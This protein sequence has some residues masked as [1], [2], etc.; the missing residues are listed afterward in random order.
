LL[1]LT[2]A[3]KP[4]IDVLN[5]LAFAYTLVSVQESEKFT[6]RAMEASQAIDYSS[7]VAESFKI[8]GIVYYIRGEYNLATQY[9]YEA[10]KLYEVLLDKPGQARVLNNLALI[11]LA[12]EDFEKVYDLSMK[13][14]AIKRAAGDS[15][16]VATSY[17]ALAEVYL[18]QQRYADAMNQ[19]KEALNRYRQFG[20]EW[21]TSHA[22]L[23]VGEI[24]HAQKNYPFALSYYKDALRFAR[25]STDYIQVI[26]AYKKI[27]QLYL[28]TN[29]FDSAYYYVKSA[30]SLAR[31]KNNRNNEMQADQLL[32][33]YFSS[34][35]VLDSALFYT[36]ATMAIER[37]IFNHQKSE[38]IATL[39]ML[40]T[41]EKKDQ[42]LSF[43]KKIVRRQ[44]VA[45]IGVSLILLLTVVLG[46]KFYKLNKINRQA[47]EDMIKLNLEVSLMNENLETLVQ[48]RTEKIKVQNQKLIDFTFFTAHEVRG[49]VA[50][51]LGL[52]E[53][54]K[55]KELDEEDRNQ[56]LQRLEEAS[57]QLDDVIRLI[58][59]KL[60]KGDQL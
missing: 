21:G 19:C 4:R 3:G 57:V 7:G 58:N 39:Q 14:L 45:I 56:I 27:G 6:R 59:R 54:A 37:E 24:Y 53:L 16:G 8:L 23:Q 22:I 41:S 13:S 36:K 29:R 11:S 17:L 12:Q 47:K 42:E 10:L 55:L 30:R 33:D 52:I 40:Y 25:L 26:N 32:A 38:Q 20:N 15:L 49:P 18:H 46:T 9:S 50:R 35:D 31:Q 60:E 34:I 5:K 51:I 43:Q 2:E 48:E 44:Y 28:Q 1:P